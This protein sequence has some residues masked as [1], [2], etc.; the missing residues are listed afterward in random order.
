MAKKRNIWKILS[1]ISIVISLLFF[2]FILL[3]FISLLFVGDVQESGNIAVVRITGPIVSDRQPGAFATGTSSY[4]IMKL[5]KTAEEDDDIKAIIVEINSPGGSAVASAEIGDK[6]KKIEKPTVAVIRELGASGGYWIASAA[7][8]IYAHEL[9]VTG[10]IGVIGSYVEIA[11]LLDKY[12]LTYQRFVS[13]KYKDAGSSLKELNEDEREMIQQVLDQIYDAFVLEVSENRGLPQ[14]KVRDLADG[15]IMLGSE[16]KKQGLIDEFGGREEAI[17][18]LEK[19]LGIEQDVAVYK[20]KTTLG[21]IFS[22]VQAEKGY[23]IGRGIGDSIVSKET[24]EI[25]I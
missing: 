23:S 7:D 25:K 21:D 5:L 10:S 2:A 3:G 12:N 11:G 17:S 15:F 20:S 14:E 13:G 1:T 8:K 9:S 24:L 16:A 18:Y 6:I 19:K 22:G 4:E